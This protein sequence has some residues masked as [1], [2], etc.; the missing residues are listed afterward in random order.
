MEFCRGGLRDFAGCY[1]PAFALLSIN[2]V[3]SLLDV[4][5]L[6][7]TNLNLKHIGS[8]YNSLTWKKIQIFEAT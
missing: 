5:S 6:N 4:T 3:Y 2:C 1:L 8:K 7:L